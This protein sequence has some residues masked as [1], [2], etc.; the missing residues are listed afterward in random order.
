MDGGRVRCPMVEVG[1]WCSRQQQTSLY[2]NLAAS[3]APPPRPPASQPP[4]QQASGTSPRAASMK[5]AYYQRRFAVIVRYNSLI[6]CWLSEKYLFGCMGCSW[7][8][9][10]KF[11][12]YTDTR[13]GWVHFLTVSAGAAGGCWACTE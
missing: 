7:G 9:P 13:V 11:S 1:G 10:Q 12:C 2:F 5:D 8:S 4:P 6:I 3:A